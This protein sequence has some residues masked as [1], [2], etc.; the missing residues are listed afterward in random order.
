MELSSFLGAKTRKQALLGAVF[1]SA[2]SV[3]GDYIAAFVHTE[4][5][6]RSIKGTGGPDKKRLQI[7]ESLKSNEKMVNAKI[8][9]MKGTL[10]V[11]P[12][13][14]RHPLPV[15]PLPLAS[16]SDEETEVAASL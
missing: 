11:E 14:L 16:D 2:I 7:M 4:K 3:Q 1:R 13:P 9:Y 12:P 6:C 8:K 10:P 15:L 5:A